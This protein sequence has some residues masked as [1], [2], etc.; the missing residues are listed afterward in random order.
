MRAEE[1]LHLI[2]ESES[3]GSVVSAEIDFQ[4]EPLSLKLSYSSFSK[5]AKIT[6]TGLFDYING[7]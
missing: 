5:G 7:S 3:V 2:W 4:K 6:K 1:F